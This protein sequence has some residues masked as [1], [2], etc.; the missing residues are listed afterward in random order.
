MSCPCLEFLPHLVLVDGD[1]SNVRARELGNVAVRAADTAA[2]VQNL[3]AR[4]DAKP[5]AKV[6]FV[7]LE[8]DGK[9]H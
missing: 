6:I 9:G 7:P 2:A 5:T 4:I 3:R 8:G 1:T